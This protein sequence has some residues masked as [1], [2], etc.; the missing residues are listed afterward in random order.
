MS[1]LAHSK[2]HSI[3]RISAV[4]IALSLVFI[5]GVVSQTTAYMSHNTGQYLANAVGMSLGVLPNELNQ[6]TAALTEKEQQLA[7]RE[8]AIVEREISLGL[9]SGQ[10]TQGT[11]RATY[12]LSALLFILLVMIV[13]NYILDFSRQRRITGSN[14]RWVQAEN[15]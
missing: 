15:S 13:F 6:I 10:T 2:Y 11:D 7:R 4:V 3:L 9:A 12:I 5:S 8:T 1:P 14:Q